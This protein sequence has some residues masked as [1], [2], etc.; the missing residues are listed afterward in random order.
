MLSSCVMMCSLLDG[1]L[2][3]ANMVVLSSADAD[4]HVEDGG[5]VQW[6][7]IEGYGLG[8]WEK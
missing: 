7:Q 8:P 6:Q 3:H 5:G 2:R 1:A 4:G